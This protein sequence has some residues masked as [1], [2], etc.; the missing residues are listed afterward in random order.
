MDHK[1]EFDKE[2][3]TVLK[4]VMTSFQNKCIILHSNKFESA[5]IKKVLVNECNIKES[6]VCHDE[7]PNNSSRMDLESFLDHPK[8]KIGVFQAKFVTGMESCNL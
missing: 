1:N 3:G 6:I 8:D 2:F 7:Y 4:D 5:L